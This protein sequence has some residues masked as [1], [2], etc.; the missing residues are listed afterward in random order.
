MPETCAEGAAELE[1]R[2]DEL[3]QQAA[4]L[5]ARSGDSVE[6]GGEDEVVPSPISPERRA[7]LNS[8]EA[9]MAARVKQAP[10]FADL[11]QELEGNAETL[12]ETASTSLE[13]QPSLRSLLRELG[14]VRLEKSVQDMTRG[15]HAVLQ[16]EKNMQPGAIAMMTTSD[17]KLL[18]GMDTAIDKA[19]L[20]IVQ[21]RKV[22]KSIKGNAGLLRGKVADWADTQSDEPQDNP[23]RDGSLPSE[24]APIIPTKQEDLAKKIRGDLDNAEDVASKSREE[25]AN[26]TTG[27]ESA[28]VATEI[29]KDKEVVSAAMPTCTL[30]GAWLSPTCNSKQ[31]RA[32]LSRRYQHHGIT[33]FL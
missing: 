13:F 14:P 9:S 17:A 8:V 25:S 12:A 31:T 20:P 24:E 21:L 29:P 3:S 30:A 7:E 15:V 6:G 11:K 19:L 18:D 33:N 16:A 23:W 5:K 32:K 10:T 2:I 26:V 22:L 28:T 1:T 4:D 27:K